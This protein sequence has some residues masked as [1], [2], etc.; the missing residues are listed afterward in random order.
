MISRIVK[1]LL[2]VFV[3]HVLLVLSPVNLFLI[4]LKVPMILN[5]FPWLFYPLLFFSPVITVL[6]ALRSTPSHHH[7]FRWIF[8]IA[9]SLI[10]YTPV[11]VSYFFFTL[12]SN[13]RNCLLVFLFPILIGLLS[14][15]GSRLL[16]LPHTTSLKQ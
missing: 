2:V 7:P 6:L 4:S 12:L 8:P 16:S 14:F 9:V 13:I 3:Y 10:G 1:N 5:V 15:W 11:I